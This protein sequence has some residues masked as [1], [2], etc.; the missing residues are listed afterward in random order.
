MAGAQQRA[1][2]GLTHLAHFGAVDERHEE[3]RDRLV[4]EE[5]QH[6]VR[7]PDAVDRR[8]VVLG[9]PR[10]QQ[11]PHVLPQREC[12]DQVVCALN[13]ANKLHFFRVLT[14]RRSDILGIFFTGA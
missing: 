3:Q 9:P 6:G 12:Q 1:G 4:G 5:Q 11:R 13:E 2:E 7:E 10:R 8:D 14:K